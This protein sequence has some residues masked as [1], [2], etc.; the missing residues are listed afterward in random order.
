MIQR[1][2]CE[3]INMQTILAY[4]SHSGASKYHTALQC[5]VDRCGL[6]SSVMLSAASSNGQTSTGIALVFV[7]TALVACIVV[8]VAHEF[9]GKRRKEEHSGAGS[10]LMTEEKET[11]FSTGGGSNR[12]I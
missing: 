10:H 8:G 11:D 7:M 3:S 6:N 2:I 1:V 4:Q 5:I 12:L 9:L